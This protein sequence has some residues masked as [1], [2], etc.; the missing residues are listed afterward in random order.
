MAGEPYPYPTNISSVDGMYGF[1][2]EVTNGQL[3][4]L[5]VFV[6]PIVIFIVLKKLDVRN[7]VNFATS[8][9]LTTFLGSFLWAGGYL[10]GRI[11]VIPLLLTVF[12][13]IYL[14]IND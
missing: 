5:L 4:S 13:G 1:A 2:N 3:S 9:F 8:M 12:A 11:I 14:W 10:D 7:D 6:F